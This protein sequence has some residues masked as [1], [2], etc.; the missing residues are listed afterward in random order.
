MAEE[1]NESREL[2]ETMGI[3]RANWRRRWRKD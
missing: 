2:V 1:A 3:G